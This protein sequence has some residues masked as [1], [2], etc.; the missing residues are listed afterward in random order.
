MVRDNEGTEVAPLL[1]DKAQSKFLAKMGISRIPTTVSVQT[2]RLLYTED[3][4]YC[5]LWE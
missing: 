3:Y 2:S 4:Y 1:L 5:V